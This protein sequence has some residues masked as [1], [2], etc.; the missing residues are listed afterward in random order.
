MTSLL[1]LMVFSCIPEPASQSLWAPRSPDLGCSTYVLYHSVTTLGLRSSIS[2]YKKLFPCRNFRKSIHSSSSL[3]RLR[4]LFSSF[5]RKYSLSISYAQG[6]SGGKP[7]T[8]TR[9]LLGQTQKHA[10]RA[11]PPAICSDYLRPLLAFTR[12]RRLATE[13]AESA[14]PGLSFQLAAECLRLSV[15]LAPEIQNTQNKLILSPVSLPK[16]DRQ[17]DGWTQTCIPV[18]PLAIRISATSSN[19]PGSK[20]RTSYITLR[21]SCNWSNVPTIDFPFKT[22]LFFPPPFLIPPPLFV[23]TP[24][25]SA[26]PP[27]LKPRL[28]S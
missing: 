20:P 6:Q 10:S 9:N 18:T 22:H 28:H 11:E 2:K 17:T 23:F 14:A 4:L 25:F 5:N 27:T 24:H 26:P 8:S 7:D 13:E 3:A 15:P 16:T 12:R 21:T 19:R 1:D